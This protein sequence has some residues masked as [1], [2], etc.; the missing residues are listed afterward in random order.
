MRSLVY[1]SFFVFNA[2]CVSMLMATLSYVR[3]LTRCSIALAELELFLSGVSR[4]YISFLRNFQVLVLVLL[5][6]VVSI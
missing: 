6:Q 4:N 2:H 3:N 5:I 1:V